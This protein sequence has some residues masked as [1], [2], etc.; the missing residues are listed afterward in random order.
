MSE[1]NFFANLTEE[2]KKI[3]LSN[4]QFMTSDDAI[5]K[6]YEVQWACNLGYHYLKNHNYKKAVYFFEECIKL[7]HKNIADIEQGE[8]MNF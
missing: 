2:E 1:S 4:V 5:V 6:Y 8:H 7:Y 3:A